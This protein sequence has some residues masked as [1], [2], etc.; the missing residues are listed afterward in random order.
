MRKYIVG[1]RKSFG[2]AFKGIVT[3]LKSQPNARIHLLAA[4][5]VS[6]AGFYFKIS[7]A[8]WIYIAI[9]IALVWLAEAFNTALEYLTDLASPQFH[10]LAEKAK[11]SAAAAVLIA[12]FLALV[13][14]GIVFLPKMGI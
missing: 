5:I 4:V 14:A 2:Y 1:R 11:D 9:A 10:H 8:E 7:S 3:V 6:A 12:A 13:I